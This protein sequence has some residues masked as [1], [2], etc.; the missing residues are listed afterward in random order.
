[1]VAGQDMGPTASGC[2]LCSYFHPTVHLSQAQFRTD[3]ELQMAIPIQ[4]AI[5]QRRVLPDVWLTRTAVVLFITALTVAS[6]PFGPPPAGQ[7]IWAI[8][9]VGCFALSV[10]AAVA[11]QTRKHRVF[12]TRLGYWALAFLILSAAIMVAASAGISVGMQVP[13]TP[14]VLISAGTMALVVAAVLG[15]LAAFRAD[16]AAV[17]FLPTTP[18]GWWAAAF[19]AVG[20]VLGFSP[21]AVLTPAAMAGPALALAAIISYR[22]RSVLSAIALVAG[23]AQLAFFDLAFFISLFTPHP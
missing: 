3:V 10:V 18:A 14:D 8:V 19:L 1:M 15:M 23:P 9:V 12:R 5:T 4:S 6:I 11:A 21:W 16:G 20:L 22:E 17:R 13:V 7:A 2:A